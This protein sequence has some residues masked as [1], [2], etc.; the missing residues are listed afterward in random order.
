MI[1]NLFGGQLISAQ[2]FDNEDVFYLSPCMNKN[3]NIRGGV[4]IIFPQFGNCG[5]LKKHGFA[6]DLNWFEVSSYKIGKDV[7]ATYSLNINK[8]SSNNWGFDAQLFLTLILVKNSSL[9]INLKV[10]NNG[11]KSFTFSGGLHPYFALKSRKDVKISGLDN[12]E[13]IDTDPLC[14]T[15]DL[16]G[17][18]GFERL[19]LSKT[20]ISLYNGYRYLNLT[21]EGFDNWMIWNPGKIGVKNIHNLPDKDWDKF[22]CIEPLVSNQPVILDPNQ[23]FNGKLMIK[24]SESKL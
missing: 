20:D 1:V 21:A 2:I 3:A 16:N 18:S 10:F 4:P 14:T 7:F 8:H 5:P 9:T 17:E 11:E 23:F 12:V 22:I 15:F 24:F 13:F 19:F 6:R